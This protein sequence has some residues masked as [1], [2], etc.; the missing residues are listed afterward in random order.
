MSGTDH[1]EKSIEE[2]R[3]AIKEMLDVNW[4]TDWAPLPTEA[5]QHVERAFE[6]LV[7]AREITQRHTGDVETDDGQSENIQNQGEKR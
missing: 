1:E 6:H 3:K 7:E 4:S 2:Q 5:E